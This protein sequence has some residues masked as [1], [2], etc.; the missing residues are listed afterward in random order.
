MNYKASFVLGLL[1][2]F[3]GQPVFSQTSSVR[4]TSQPA[5]SPDAQT[6]VFSYD[7]DLWKVPVAGGVAVRLTGMEGNETSPSFSPDG[8][9]LAFTSNQF[10]NNDVYLMPVEGGDIKQLTYHQS[11]DQMESWSWDSQTIYF[12]S[13]RYNRVSVFSVSVDG[14]TPARLFGHYHN[15]V[16]NLVEHPTED[17]FLFNESWESFNFPQRKRYVGP[18]NPD[19]KSYNTRTQEFTELTEWEGKDFWPMMDNSGTLYFV[20]D[21]DNG[22][23]NLYTISDGTVSALTTFN[24]S[25][26]EPAISASGEVIVFE[27]E[28]QIFTYNT[29][30][31]TST[32]VPISIFKNATLAQDQS[33]NVDGNISYV[34]LS[35]DEKKMAFISRGELFVSDADGKYIKQLSTSPMGR[36]LEVKWLK[37]NKTLIFNQTVDGYQNW[38]TIAADGAGKE[39]QITNDEQNNR[40]LAFNSDL[41]QGVYLS[42]RN[43]LRLLDLEAMESETIAKDEFWGFYND[44]PTF[45]PDDKFILYSAYRHFEQDLFLY[46]IE[47]KE[48]LNLTASGVSESGG[49]WSP[50]GKYIYFASARTQPSYPRGGGNSNIYRVALDRFEQPFKS[51]EF[52]KL[53]IEKDE[54]KS[55]DSE[56]ENPVEVSVNTEELMQRI[57]QIGPSFGDQ[58]S[59][60]VLQEGDKTMVLF[61]S[62]HEGGSSALY[63]T[64]LSPF[65]SPKTEKV[66]GIS[67]VAG[68]GISQGKVLAIGGGSI[69]T[70]NVSG[71]KATKVETSKDFNRNLKAEFN[72]MFDEFWVGLEENFYNETFHDVDWKGIRDRYKTYLPFIT[73]RSDLRRMNNDMLG[74]LNSSHLGF[75]SSGPEENE[76]YS[77]VSL[78][79]G[80]IFREDEPFVVA[81]I[82]KDGPFDVSGKEVLPGDELVSVD[83]T[84][85][86]KTANRESYFTRPKMQDELT[87][88]FKRGRD[89][90]TEKVHPVS[91]GSVRNNL[92][93]EWVDTN[94]K[95]V[96]EETDKRVAYVHMKNMGGGEL[97]NFLLEM[98]TEWYN[99]DALIFDLRYNTGGNVHDAV[100]QFLSQ[101]PYAKWKYRE[102]EFA[103][104]PNFAPASKPIILLIN[105]QSLSDAEVTT[106]GFQELELGTVVGTATYRWIIFTSGKGLVDGSF[107]RLPS[108][109]VYSLDGKNLERTGL[110][111][112]VPVKNTFKDRLTGADPQLQ[113]A[114]ELALEELGEN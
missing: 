98:T 70:V 33:F 114:I 69:Y 17:A 55:D 21:R 87:L 38:F 86:D 113:K 92:Y 107:Y 43:E 46:D 8:K 94:Q 35:P 96:D 39:N 63:V 1:V 105:E 79:P 56:A 112:D 103:P 12:R 25:V 109:G 5:V 102:G 29:S 6:I 76:F 20:S 27:K 62:N 77:T 90:F 14:G 71:A 48:T 41:T 57:E 89:N 72:Q 36:V 10:G 110:E 26:R 53:F 108:W 3:L 93:D 28:Y 67:S 37:D 81:S 101:K 9:W 7:S 49:F 51:D 23:F 83:G 68:Y 85:I 32:L 22:E 15:N 2:S 73:S 40:N 80:L 106:A 104:Q 95:M 74:E 52:D 88:T 84:E 54:E 34:D 100:I 64:T 58:Y 16:H 4:F 60:V 18:F 24:T 66:E 11:S 47:A 65:E 42:G 61:Q 91:Y 82:V 45:S 50:D 59:P 30:T 44:Q 13:D 31:G 78:S 97:Q 99:R 19:I 111:P 75:S